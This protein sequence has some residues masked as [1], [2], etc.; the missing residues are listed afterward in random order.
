MSRR[1]TAAM[2]G[3]C[4]ALVLLTGVHAAGAADKTVAISGKAYIFNHMDTGISDA[5]IKVREF[6]KISTTTDELGD[7]EL[8]VPDDANVTP[9]IPSGEG[10][11]T[12]RNLDDNS[13]VGQVQTHWNEI[14]LQTFHTRGTA[15]RNAN[16][17]APAD[18]EFAGLKALLSVPARSDGRPEQCAIVTTASARNIRDVDYR[19]FEE[20]TPHGEPGATSIEYPALDGP[21]YFN[22]SVIPD[23]SKAETSEDGGIIWPIVPTGTYRIVTSSPDTRFAS[24]LATCKPG[25]VVNANPP[26][27]AYELSPGEKPLGASNVAGKVVKVKAYRKNGKRLVSLR[28]KLGEE[29]ALNGSYKSVS[30]P[31]VPALVGVLG[32]GKIPSGT[33][34]L[35]T[36]MPGFGAKRRIPL[37]LK[38]TMKDASGVSFTSNLRVTLPKLK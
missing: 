13:P 19:T 2:T 30:K 8:K 6:P 34:I 15:I 24:F 9:Y 38:V 37:K 10:L 5:P 36:R 14:D 7:Y 16:F 27:G 17:Q 28:V 20:R 26:W 12:R 1:L 25:R 23:R 29:L 33:H 3:T 4:T 32:K 21:I 22:E 11:L 18:A 31:G 35:K